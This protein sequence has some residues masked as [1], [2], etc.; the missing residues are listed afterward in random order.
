MFFATFIDETNGDSFLPAL[1]KDVLAVSNVYVG[2]VDAGSDTACGV[3]AAESFPDTE[4]NTTLSIRQIYVAEPFRRQGAATCM[5][6]LLQDSA[7]QIGAGEFVCTVFGKDKKMVRLLKK[8]GFLK[9]EIKSTVYA[10]LLKDIVRKADKTGLTHKSLEKL[11][12]REWEQLVLEADKAGYPVNIHDS[13]EQK[14]S[15]IAF[16]QGGIL[17]GIL[18]VTGTDQAL[19]VESVVVFGRNEKAIISELV[20]GFCTSA[21]GY[22]PETRVT[23]S[24]LDDSDRAACLLDFARLSAGKTDEIITFT[25]EAPVQI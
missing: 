4:G 3:L 12:P 25:W 18:L 7:A 22:D 15:T 14:V 20:T 10:F 13:Y 23:L 19:D 5:I 8:T 1:R 16:D 11:T 9:E 17:Q 21:E 24:I 2:V 6:R